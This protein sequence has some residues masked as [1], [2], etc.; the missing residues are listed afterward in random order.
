MVAMVKVPG[1]DLSLVQC[2]VFL[3][4]QVCVSCKLKRFGCGFMWKVTD[5]N[6]TRFGS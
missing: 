6:F 1:L 4:I 2:T 3:S 5:G